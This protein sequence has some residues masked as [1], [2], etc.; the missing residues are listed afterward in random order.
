VA[1]NVSLL[2]NHGRMP[3]C[4]GMTSQIDVRAGPS[5]RHS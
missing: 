5:A 2:R 3:A 1:L 4:A